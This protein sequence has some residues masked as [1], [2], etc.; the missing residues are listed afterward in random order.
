MPHRWSRRR[1]VQG[2][3]AMGLGLLAG[4]GRLPGQAPPVSARRPGIT[5]HRIA[6]LLGASPSAANAALL[7]AFRVSLRDLG[8]VEGHNL[9]LEQHHA[10]GDDQLAELTAELVRLQTELILVPASTV[11]RAAR[12]ATTTLPIVSAGAGDLVAR[13]LAASHARPGGNVTGLS[14]PPLAGKQLQLLQEAVPMLARV[15]V[16]FSTSN[17]DFEPAPYEA[18][19]RTLGLQVQFV[20]A[21]VH[22][23]PEPVFE[24]LIRDHADG[25][26]VPLGQG[27]AGLQTRIAA[28]ALNS[29]LPSLWA[30]SEAVGRG[31]LM[32]YG[33]NRAAL[34]RRAAYYVDRILKGTKPADL[35]IEEP[36]EF[37]FIINAKTA[38]ALG[39][40]M[41]H[42]VLLQTTEIIP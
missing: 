27:I 1:V 2:A 30:Q 22:A 42:H 18:A 24:A 31:G 36:R 38:Q 41:P 12:A 10:I 14:T 13:R 40:T 4:C 11:A 6:Y 7:S 26:L 34:Y 23:D 16:L 20:G 15:A 8:Y 39:L 37:D 19:A 35:P 17:L 28:L 33:P 9:L 29:G 25:L 32:A 3:G 5:V 21:N